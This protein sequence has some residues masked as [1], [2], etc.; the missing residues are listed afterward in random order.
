MRFDQV[1]TRSPREDTAKTAVDRY[2]VVSPRPILF[3]YSPHNARGRI[4]PSPAP[5]APACHG[6]NHRPDQ[7][8]PYHNTD[9][10][11]SPIANMNILQLIIRAGNLPSPVLSPQ[12]P[13]THRNLMNKMLI[14]FSSLRS[15]VHIKIRIF[16]RNLLMYIPPPSTKT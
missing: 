5:K 2:T 7:V 8:I 4:P 12:G 11:P 16:T 1:E 13:H 10:R 15:V 6:S 9:K 14:R 3:R